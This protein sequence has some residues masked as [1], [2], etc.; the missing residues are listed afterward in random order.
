MS[1]SLM[2]SVMSLE[3]VKNCC[4]FRLDLW[5]GWPFR[6]ES[7]VGRFLFLLV[8]DGTAEAT[9]LLV[10]AKMPELAILKKEAGRDL[11]K[12]WE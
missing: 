11:N 9:E 3:W 2:S 10:M 6:S 12:R 7:L 1:S 5:S 4:E 8:F